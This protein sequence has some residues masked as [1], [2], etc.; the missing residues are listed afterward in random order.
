[1]ADLELPRRWEGAHPR[2]GTQPNIYRP[3]QSCEGYVFTPVCLSTG[4][5][6]SVHAGIPPPP[7]ADPPESTPPGA[8]TPREQAPPEQTFPRAYPPPE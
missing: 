7:G 3:Q 1:M 6:P 4:G 5:S 8:G 2:G